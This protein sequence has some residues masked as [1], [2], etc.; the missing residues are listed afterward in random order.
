MWKITKAQYDPIKY[1]CS[2]EVAKLELRSTS[3]YHDAFECFANDV[4][5]EVLCTVKD[6]QKKLSLL[7]YVQL[8]Q[9]VTDELRN[10]FSY[11][12]KLNT[13]DCL[14]CVPKYSS[15]SRIFIYFFS[16]NGLCRALETLCTEFERRKGKGTDFKLLQKS[17]D[18]GTSVFSD[19]KSYSNS[20]FSS[21]TSTSVTN[22]QE[23]DGV[24]IGSLKVK[25][26]NGSILDANVRAI[27][28]ATNRSLTFDAGVS[29]VIRKAAGCVYEIDCK[30][31]LQKEN[32]LKTS[33]CYR[34]D[35][36]ILKDKFKYILHAVGPHWNDYEKKEDCMYLLAD[37]VTNVLKMADS[38]FIVSVAMPAISSGKV[39]NIYFP[40]HL[41]DEIKGSFK[42]GP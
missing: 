21:S 9:A 23:N 30:T 22:N 5:K 16:S 41:L 18:L 13:I 7:Y 1:F 35:P 28:N 12:E 17:D 8:N 26:Y 25:V 4:S 38:L 20:T 37:T 34:S 2:K 32:S 36:G 3:L 24:L 29:R 11:L 6:I 31:L 40:F 10:A 15:D 14:V 39:C 27:V 42:N 33:K 19:Y